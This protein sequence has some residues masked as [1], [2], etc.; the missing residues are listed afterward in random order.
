M[1][2]PSR[3]EIT[4]QNLDPASGS[5]FAFHHSLDLFH[6]DPTFVPACLEKEL[7]I[8]QLYFSRGKS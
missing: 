4:A 5:V 7:F 6:S 8:Q 2:E 3:K 1:P